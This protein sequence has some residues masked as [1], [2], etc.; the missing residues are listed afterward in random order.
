MLRAVKYKLS[1]A[2][3]EY[4]DFMH[5]HGTI[6]QSRFFLGFW[7]K[8]YREPLVV[9]VLDGDSIVGGC[10]VRLGPNILGRAI[11][12]GIYFGPVV[13][14]TRILADVFNLIV[15]TLSKTCISYNI[16]ICP[17]HAEILA[18]NCNL[19]GFSKKDIEFLHWDISGSAESLWKELP[20]GK[21]SGINR[22]RREGVIIEEIETPEQVERFFK[23]HSMSMGKSKL[24]T[25]PLSYYKDLIATLKPEGL[26]TG[27]LA[28]HPK[29][30]EVM[31][32]RI[33]LLGMHHDAT[34]LASGQDNRYRKLRG[35]DLLMWHCVEFLKSKGFIIAD[36]VGL[37]KGDSARAH[38]IRHFKTTLAGNNGRRLPS[39]I[40]SRAV[41]GI[42]PKSINSIVSF[43]K[44]LRKFV[45][46]GG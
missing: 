16:T 37:P 34:F 8:I 24:E 13:A 44:A 45:H 28:L 2:P 14:D 39:Y 40:L 15:E 46:K 23:V 19:R 9:A 26:A 21:K 1:E 38:G 20:K 43:I 3:K 25:I 35:T 17:E 10:A 30:R 4:W 27:F 12:A 32:G 29:T 6:F 33:L 41:W 18:A 36:L 7:T 42:N 5:K 22:G 11:R 31:A